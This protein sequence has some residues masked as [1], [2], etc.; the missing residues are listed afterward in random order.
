M[1]QLCQ[2]KLLFRL[3]ICSKNAGLQYPL[4]P[5]QP[6]SLFPSGGW[7]VEIPKQPLSLYFL[8]ASGWLV[9]CLFM[10]SGGWLV[11][12]PSTTKATTV[13]LFPSG[14]WL[15]QCLFMASGGWLVEIPSTTKA[16]TVSL[17]P[18]SGW[19]VEIPKLLTTFKHSSY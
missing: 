2:N 16:T 19:L 15:V 7:L 11:E 6:L 4:L 13:S 3:E 1:G 12:I 14:G 10:A 9:Q 5:K 8:P 18:S 17:F